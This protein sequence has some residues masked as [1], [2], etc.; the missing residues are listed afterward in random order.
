M[1]ASVTTGLNRIF[2]VV[3]VHRFFH[4]FYQQAGFVYRQK[5]IPIGAPDN[6]DDVPAGTAKERF[7]LLND[8]AIASYRTIETL[9]IA[10]YYPNEIVQIFP[11]R[12]GESSRCFRLIHFPVADK[13]PNPGFFRIK[14]AAT[15][16]VTIEDRKSTRLNS[17]H[18][19]ISYAVFCL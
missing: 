5:R 19:G 14:K 3:P 7:Q 11:A 12:Q 2:L 8:L 17:S 1:L 15:L 18:L 9:Q 10:V 13:T 4:P 6:F 16:E